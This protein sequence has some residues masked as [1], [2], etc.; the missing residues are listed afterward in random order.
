M[1]D[2]LNSLPD[3]NDFS[4]IVE[5]SSKLQTT[6]GSM[7]GKLSCPYCA[8]PSKFI[9]SQTAD[10]K[11][12]SFVSQASKPIIPLGSNVPTI[13]NAKTLSSTAIDTSYLTG[14]L[15][16][17]SCTTCTGKGHLLVHVI[18]GQ[19]ASL[20]FFYKGSSIASKHSPDSV[21]YFLEQASSCNQIKAYSA[22]LAMYRAALDAVLFDQGF[23]KGMV[24]EKIGVLEKQIQNK[25]A[26]HW[27]GNINLDFLRVI[28][29]LANSSLHI[30]KDDLTEE[31]K[32]SAV[33]ISLVE[34]AFAKLLYEVYERQAEEN[35]ELAALQQLE[36]LKK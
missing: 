9:V 13:P 34:K 7:Y 31:K 3:L 15:Y 29:D 26:P 1:T 11:T 17:L 27:A 33:D 14:S 25:S 22:T 21:R 4:S 5:I 30:S 36:A 8:R 10:S 6:L 35:A 19:Q 20:I 24:G 32:I 18:A 28:K 2:T 16:Q 23:K 12:R